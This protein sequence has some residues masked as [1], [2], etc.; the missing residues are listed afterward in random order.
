[1][2]PAGNQLPQYRDNPGYHVQRAFVINEKPP[3]T[4]VRKDAG[5]VARRKAAEAHLAQLE[6]QAAAEDDWW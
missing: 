3:E 2:K 1:M 5:S 6:R 4:V